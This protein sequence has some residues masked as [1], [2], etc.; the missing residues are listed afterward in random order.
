MTPET[1]KH[2]NHLRDQAQETIAYFRNEKIY[3]EGPMS[4]ILLDRIIDKMEAR[5][6]GAVAEEIRRAAV[7]REEARVNGIIRKD[8]FYSQLYLEGLSLIVAKQLFTEDVSNL[9]A[10]EVK[11]AKEA[12]EHYRSLCEQ[13]VALPPAGPKK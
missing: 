6:A 4:T 13:G 12:Y 8:S 11:E 1:A 5:K 10:D 2:L 3:T 9:I 7:T